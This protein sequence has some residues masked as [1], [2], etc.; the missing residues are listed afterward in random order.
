MP[1]LLSALLVSAS[2]VAVTIPL[3]G[4]GNAG[5]A[6]DTRY[7]ANGFGA[8]GYEYSIGK[9]EISYAQYTEFLNAVAK[10]DPYGLYHENMELSSWGGILRSGTPGSYS[11]AVRPA[12]AGQGPGGTPYTYG[13]KPVVFVGWYD[14]V[15]F[16]NWMHN[17]QG[18]GDTETGAYTLLGGTPIPSNGDTV[19]RNVGA[20][21]WLPSENEWYKAAYYQP[22]GGVYYDFAT[23]TNLFPNN[24][25]PSNDTGN[26]ANAFATGL[27][28]TTGN[29]DYPMTNVGAYTLS[30]SPYGTQDQVG[31]VA[32]WNE[33]SIGVI[34]RGLRGGG[35]NGPVGA[36]HAFVRDDDFHPTT[37]GGTVGFRLATVPEPG[38]MLLVV[39]GALAAWGVK[40][41]GR[42]N[43]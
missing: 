36:G 4:V 2:A 42:R 6:P 34:F 21:W 30:V 12:A 9:T 3:V 16:A 18:N 10:S 28:Y 22:A 13:D 43:R 24:N 20:Q 14:A 1:V 29:P 33:T 40:P 41:R 25:L 32:E 11:Y 15:R 27:G 19:T 23:G 8:V 39:L 35:W 5:N 37:E 26:S 31:N 17:G 38:T 7:N